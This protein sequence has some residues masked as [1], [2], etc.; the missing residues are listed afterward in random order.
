MPDQLPTL[1]SPR[2]VDAGPRSAWPRRVGTAGLVLV[3]VAGALNLFG[4]R[5]STST[6]QEQGW[7]VAVHHA[8]VARAGLDVPWSVRVTHAG[9]LPKQVVVRVTADYFDIFEEQ[10][11]TPSPTAET[12]DGTWLVWTFASPP[13]DTMDVTFDTYV[14]PS[15][16]RGRSGEVSVL[17]DGS[18]VATTPFRTV[19]LP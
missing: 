4:L 10:G 16:H 9:G 3:V 6:R 15:S 1:E 17:L 8:S 13:G 2:G 5:T 12:D 14:Q 11:L 19:L 18:P 7:T